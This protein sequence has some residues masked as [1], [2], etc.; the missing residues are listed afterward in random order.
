MA[1]L[2]YPEPSVFPKRKNTRISSARVK[3]RSMAAEKWER[4][5]FKLSENELAYDKTTQR[6]KIGDGV[7]N[8]NDLPWLVLDVGG[9][10][11]GIMTLAEFNLFYAA[12][13][14]FKAA[15]S[16]RFDAQIAQN[17]SFTNQLTLIDNK[18]IALEEG[19]GAAV[20]LS[21]Y[22]S[23]AVFAQ[24]QT[25]QNTLNNNQNARLDAVEAVNASQTQI[26]TTQDNRITALENAPS[27]GNVDTS[28]LVT[29]TAFNTYK[30]ANDTTNAAQSQ[31]ITTLQNDL[32]SALARILALESGAGSGSG[33]GAVETYPIQPFNLIVDYTLPL[34]NTKI[35][36]ITVAAGETAKEVRL[37]D[38]A[39]NLTHP[40][41]STMMGYILRV[42]DAA[43]AVYGLIDGSSIQKNYQ[44]LGLALGQGRY[45]IKITHALQ[46]AKQ[47]IRMYVKK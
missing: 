18:V 17:L 7:N 33:G 32:T 44:L 30:T 3:L 4:L 45:L 16:L 47:N 9:N 38:S 25:A 41:G 14:Q 46:S 26:N 34:L 12:Y 39:A 10:F 28:N 2:V 24:Y 13:E 21:G 1:T 27:G 23:A 36:E 6:L 15:E 5:N 31:S 40:Y 37:I 20:D 8:W 29:L 43:G 22:I 19:A 42:E 35:L 11:Q